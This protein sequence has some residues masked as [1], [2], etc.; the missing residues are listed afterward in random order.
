MENPIHLA[1]FRALGANPTPMAFAEVYTA[2][3]QGVVEGQENPIANIYVMRFQEVQRYMSL[4]GHLIAPQVFIINTGFWN[5]MPAD[6]Q[7]IMIEADRVRQRTQVGFMREYEAEKLGII[8]QRST[9]N[10]LTREER[11]A[12]RAALES[13]YKENR[14]II[15]AELVD[16]VIAAI[17]GQ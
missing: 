11:A 8:A 14:Y 2:L 5:S 3:Q 4:T 6:L 9:V 15:G 13:I 16:R 7:E 12:F 10:D 17:E 1:S